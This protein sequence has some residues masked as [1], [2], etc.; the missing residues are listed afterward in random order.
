MNLASL[1]SRQVD[2]PGPGF[3][4]PALELR[5]ISKSFGAFAAIHDVSL[6]IQRGAVVSLIGP[7]GAGKS[8]L[9]RCVNLLEVPTQG[10]IIFAGDTIFSAGKVPPKAWQLSR[11]RGH[12]GMVFQ[13]INL[14]PHLTVL[15]NVSLPQE[16]V[17]GRTRAEAD[18]IS[19]KLL[20][21]LGVDQKS[22]DLPAQCSGGQQQRV[23]IARSLALNPKVILFDEPTSALDP[24]LGQ[25]VLA[26]MRKL[27]DEGMTMMVVTHEMHFARDVSDEV[28]V[29]VDGK[30]L[31]QGP[32]DQVMSHPREER[33]RQFLRAV[34][35]R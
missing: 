7:S 31:E 3:E 17:L 18:E 20:E 33:T 12:V 22:N 11:Y 8:T 10:E 19:R 5:N 27:A 30:I 4:G 28:V 24:E 16:R 29:M 21:R 14:F 2:V 15:R 25:E 1:R 13:S 26:V 23:A 6:T 9:L 35:D 32:P 34:L